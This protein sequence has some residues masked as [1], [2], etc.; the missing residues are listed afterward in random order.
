MKI[1][2]DLH[3]CNKLESMRR[4]QSIIR[5]NKDCEIIEAIHGFNNGAELKKLLSNPYNLH[6]K[7]IFKTLPVPLNDGRTF[8]YIRGGKNV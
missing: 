4:I 8:I 3:G 7:K 5:E 1:E 2:I 6:S